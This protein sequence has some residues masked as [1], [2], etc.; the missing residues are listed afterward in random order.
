MHVEIAFYDV[1]AAQQELELRRT[2]FD[3]ASAAAELAE[4]LH[5]AGTIT[6][7]A[8]AR[9]RDHREQARV[10][11]A[12][13]EV[14]VEEAREALNAQL[15]LSG[16]QTGWT[17]VERLPDVPDAAPELDDL[18]QV[19]VGESLELAALRAEADAASGRVGQAR[20]RAIL[21]T[22]GAGVAL[23]TDHGEWHAGPALRLGLPIFDQ[24]QGPRARAKSDLRRVRHLVTATAVELRA[25]ARAARQVA[26]EAHDEAIHIRDVILPLRDEILDELV[27][28]YN[29]MN[30]S[31][32][33]LLEA[34]R[35]LVDAGSQYIDAIRRYWVATA[36]ASALRRGVLPE[37]MPQ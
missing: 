35:E 36:R 12:R 27:L 19:A 34:K 30:A 24:N 18:E 28:Q 17:T 25:Q 21:P 6:D 13:A 4:R 32:F 7:L 14:A 2:A 20:L 3:A 33:E 8:Y 9:E 37:E 16:E 11:V 1:L 23:S 5:D 15:G 22:V 26:L 29:A 31:T 10:D